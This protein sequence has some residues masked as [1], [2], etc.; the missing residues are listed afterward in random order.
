[1]TSQI[2]E[3]L[4]KKYYLEFDCHSEAT[5]SYWRKFGHFQSVKEVDG[6]YHL[7]GRLFGNFKKNSIFHRILNFPTSIQINDLLR[8]LSYNDIAIGKSL[9]KKTGR[10]FDF[11]TAKNLLILN[12]LRPTLDILPIKNIVIIGDGYGTLGCILKSAFPKAK[13]IDKFR[14]SVDI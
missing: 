8:G 1:M 14:A 12:L 7:N 13:I 6:K 2:I 4:Y 11:D 3:T 5:S 9:A 10:I